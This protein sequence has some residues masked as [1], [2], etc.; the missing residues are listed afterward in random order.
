MNILQKKCTLA[1]LMLIASATQASPNAVAE[2]RKAMIEKNMVAF[3]RVLESGEIGLNEFS[4]D[5]ELYEIACVSTYDPYSAFFDRLLE[6]GL[7]P[8]TEDPLVSVYTFSLLVCASREDSLSAFTALLDAGARSDIFLCHNCS[9]ENPETLVA[10][11]LRQP[12]FFLEI[13]N[14]RELTAQEL[15][16][17][18]RRIANVYYHK[19]YNDQPLNEFYA[20]FLRERGIDV[21]PKG[22]NKPE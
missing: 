18:S 4:A 10:R 8:S 14:R 12:E 20:D 3:D 19:T 5:P 15:L 1:F 11:V 2:L 7:D 6:Y 16:S 13:V 17:M 22:P 9:S 21:T